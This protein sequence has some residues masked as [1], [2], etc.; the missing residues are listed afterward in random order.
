MA[1]DLL[2]QAEHDPLASSVLITTSH[3]LA[4]GIGSA[5]AQQLEDHPRREICE[6]S[7]RDWGLVVVCDDLETCAPVRADRV[8]FV[9]DPGSMAFY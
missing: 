3:Q 2:A 4:D 6:A 5:I 9:L 7:L 1:A 8:P